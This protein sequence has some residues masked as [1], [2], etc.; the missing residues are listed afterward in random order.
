MREA[1]NPP[2]GNKE[3]NIKYITNL[4]TINEI[5]ILGVRWI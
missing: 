1:L 4:L 3:L 5:P 2:K